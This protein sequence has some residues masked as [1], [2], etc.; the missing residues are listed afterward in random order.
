M[1][2]LKDMPFEY[3]VVAEYMQGGKSI[4]YLTKHDFDKV[5]GRLLEMGIDKESI[6]KQLFL[7][8]PN[9]TMNEIASAISKTRPDH[10]MADSVSDIYRYR[11]HINGGNFVCGLNGKR[12]V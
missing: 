5:K 12:S 10:V 6:E 11:A 1:S 4:V 2:F 7:Y 3:E 8:S 9:L